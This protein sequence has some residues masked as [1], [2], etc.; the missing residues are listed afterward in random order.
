MENIS[1]CRVGQ[2]E[3]KG[4][5]RCNE[6]AKRGWRRKENDGENRRKREEG[7]DREKMKGSRNEE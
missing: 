6:K 7:S 2:R 5:W 1:K 4:R 3:N